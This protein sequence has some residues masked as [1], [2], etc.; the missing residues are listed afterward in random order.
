MA[1]KFMQNPEYLS[2]PAGHM[3][4]RRAEERHEVD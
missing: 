3:A 2:I 1:G 4:D